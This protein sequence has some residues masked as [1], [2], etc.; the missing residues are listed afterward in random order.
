[1]AS[2]AP[3]FRPIIDYALPPRCAGCGVIVPDDGQLCAPCWGTLDFLTGEGCA[4]CG[5]P[6]IADG[7]VCAP[8]LE[9]PPRHDGVRAA[10][11]YGDLARDLALRLKYGRRVGL[12]A[13]LARAMM[14]H[15]PEDAELLVPVPL[16]RWRIWQ[17]GFNQSA[18]MARHIGNERSIP[19]ALNVLRRVRAT[20]M[21]GGLGAKARADAVR[22][23]FA[24]PAQLRPQLK[25]KSVILVDDVYTSGATANACASALKRAGATRVVVLC[26]ARVLKGD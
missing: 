13:M 10:V 7:M 23:V 16:H 12:A 17:R 21:L 25:G 14:R 15:V 24:V 18:L 6:G 20:P 8:C 26:W 1:M 2:L 19:L 3:L 4:L 22:G 11:A 9:R 5:L